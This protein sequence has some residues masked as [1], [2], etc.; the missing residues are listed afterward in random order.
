YEFTSLIN[1][2]FSPE[3]KVKIIELMWQVAYSDKEL[4]KYEEALVRKIADLLYVPHTAFI[5]AKHRVI[6][7]LDENR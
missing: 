3:E 4:E 2:G 1:N 5:A 7:S 6:S